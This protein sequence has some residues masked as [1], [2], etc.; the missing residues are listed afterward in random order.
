MRHD[1]M[2]LVPTAGIA[3]AKALVP[4]L[5]PAQ[6]RP[7]CVAPETGAAA[8]DHSIQVVLYTAA[9][10]PV[11]Q[12]AT[13][14]T[15]EMAVHDEGVSQ[16]PHQ[17]AA[18][19]CIHHVIPHLPVVVPK[20]TNPKVQYPLPHPRRRAPARSTSACWSNQAIPATLQP[21]Q[22]CQPSCGT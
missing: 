9:F 10:Q 7:G 3:A 18:A 2:Q 4:L 22:R 19:S 1:C 14:R 5:Q 13:G 21:L 6:C 15:Q 20:C 11:T 16:S 17:L 12:F 8:A